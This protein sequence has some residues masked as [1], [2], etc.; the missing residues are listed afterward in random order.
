MMAARTAPPGSQGSTIA[1]V[2]IE[3]DV[4]QEI[5]EF[6]RKAITIIKFTIY[7]LIAVFTL[8]SYTDSH[9]QA[10]KYIIDPNFKVHFIF[11]VIGN[12][13]LA[14]GCYYLALA[15]GRSRYWGLCGLT[16]L[17]GLAVILL[18]A[19]ENNKSSRVNSK[20]QVLAYAMK[21][22]MEAGEV[23]MNLFLGFCA[24][25]FTYHTLGKLGVP[26]FVPKAVEQE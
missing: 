18:L 13:A 1:S 9:R 25:C 21:R 6:K 23:A 11:Y 16:G 5:L 3:D 7:Y 4:D 15:K 2:D 10:L 26:G 19:D 17:P 22:M 8:D 24:G 20:I 12:L 14:Y